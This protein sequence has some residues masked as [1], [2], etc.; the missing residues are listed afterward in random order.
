MASRCVV[1]RVACGVSRWRV[2]RRACGEWL[3]A[4]GVRRCDVQRVVCCVACGVWRVASGL[5]PRVTVVFGVENYQA[6]GVWRVTVVWHVACHSVTSE[7]VTGGEWRVT[8][9]VRGN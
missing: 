1:W 2:V 3:D 8:V 6:C 5:S 4:C 9:T 7:T